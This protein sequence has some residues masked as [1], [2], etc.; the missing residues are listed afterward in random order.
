MSDEKSILYWNIGGQQSSGRRDD[1]LM[2]SI[3][4]VINPRFN[5][6]QTEAGSVRMSDQQLSTDVKPLITSM[7]S[8]LTVAEVFSKSFGDR[9]GKKGSTNSQ[10]V[11]SGLYT[12]TNITQKGVLLNLSSVNIMA[13]IVRA[14]TAE[15]PRLHPF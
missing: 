5:V 4:T 8:G 14:V 11:S 7:I 13:V 10:K 2:L 3:T 15:R 1:E 6:C 9:Y 12:S